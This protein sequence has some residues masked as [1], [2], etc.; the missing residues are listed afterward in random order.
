MM[1]LVY[2]RLVGFAAG[3]LVHLFL[4]I[5]VAGYRRPRTVERVL[6]FLALAL[7]LFYAGALLALNAQLYYPDPPTATL[8]FAVVLVALGLGFLPPLLVHLHAAY[9][10]TSGGAWP[11]WL[12]AVVWAAYL[13]LAYFAPVASPRLFES[14]RFEFLQPGSGVGFSYSLW[15]GAALFACVIF[16]R[17]FQRRAADKRQQQ[18]HGALMI[19]FGTT[20][21]LVIYTYCLGRLH[22]PAWSA[23]LATAVMLAALVPSSLLGYFMLR[24]NFLEIGGQR[25]LVYAVSA[26]FLALLYLSVVRRVETWLEPALPPDA[27]ASILLFVL[28]VFFEPLQRRV[29]RALRHTFERQVGRLQRL[30]SELQREAHRG[31][32][33]RLVE[34]LE[35][36][37]RQELEL[38]V[39]RLWLRGRPARE[40]ARVP[41]AG[42]PVRFPLRTADD[43]IGVLEARAYAARISGETYAA[44]QF[45][46]EQLPAVINLCRLIEEKLKLERE[47]AERERLA[48]VGQMAASISHNLKNPL[49]SMKTLVELQLENPEL[50]SSMRKDL[51]LV[52]TEIDRL[53]LKLGQLLRYAQPPVR[54]AAGQERVAAVALADHLVALLSRQAERRNVRLVLERGER[55][56]FVRGSEEALSDVLSNLVVNA[57]EVLPQ[58]GSVHVRVERRN[59]ILV[60]EVTDD[61]PGIP[62]VLRSKIFEPFFTTKPS[63]TGLGLAIVERRLAEIEGRISWE[64]PVEDGHGTRF[65]VTLPVAE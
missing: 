57:I 35:S 29:G 44:L 41:A 22:A 62:P 61:G 53:S 13:P 24:F 9:E 56:T 18:F 55:E 10:H 64:S 47:L 60:L 14:L 34:F 2:I 49:G 30:G 46:A 8:A 11:V 3:T 1:A 7:F 23:A 26:A 16:Q 59:S 43:E 51:E 42:R 52:V 12:Q 65:T 50:P 27:T 37:I 48:L 20:C 25:N 63:G 32:L 45:L 54:S 31:D 28:V 6:F 21:A 33:A 17:R 19:F 40:E 39:V 58:G 4:A 5:L 15:L 36:R 38:A